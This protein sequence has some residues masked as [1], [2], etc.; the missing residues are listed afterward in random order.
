MAGADLALILK[1]SGQDS[2]W[3]VF[4]CP[5]SGDSFPGAPSGARWIQEGKE[6][7]NPY[8]GAEMLNC[9]AEIRP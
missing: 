4:E 7:H 6:V 3:Q 9:G 2:P 8:Y 1:K 5:M